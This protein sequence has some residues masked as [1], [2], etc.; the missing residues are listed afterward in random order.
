MTAT[1][2]RNHF[3]GDAVVYDIL[4]ASGTAAEARMLVGLAETCTQRRGPFTF[5][6]PACGTARHLRWVARRH[7]R[8]IGFDLA[9]HMIDDARSRGERAGV[10]DRLTLFVADMTDFAHRVNRLSDLA[11][12]LDNTIRHLPDDDA[13]LTHFEQVAKCLKRGGAYVIGLSTTAY[14]AERPTRDVWTGTRGRC[15]VVQTAHYRPPKPPGRSEIVRSRVHVQ[16]PTG[17]ERR[18]CVFTLRT[19]SSEQL[20]ALIARSCLRLDRVLDHWGSS[21]DLPVADYC[22]LLLRPR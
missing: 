11:F 20:L 19:Y 17:A 3:Y 21:A 2:D 4:H 14:G 13:M 22:H 16:T 7:H 9:S 6:E 1:L 8:G 15:H 5:L 12:N 18:S 10:A